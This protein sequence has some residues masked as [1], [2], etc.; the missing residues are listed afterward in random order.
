MFGNLQG[1]LTLKY[2]IDCGKKFFY[3]N[4]CTLNPILLESP[5][6]KAVET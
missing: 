2:K 4:G 3:T 6:Y 1:N 5:Y